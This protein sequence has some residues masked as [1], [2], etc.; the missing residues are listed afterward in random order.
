M[1]F[2]TSAE[3]LKQFGWI[4]MFINFWVGVLLGKPIRKIDS[5]TFRNFSVI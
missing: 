4:S 2:R 3:L 1:E 5:I